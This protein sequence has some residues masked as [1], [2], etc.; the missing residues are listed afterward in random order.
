MLR[1]VLFTV[2]VPALVAHAMHPASADDL[3]GEYAIVV[4]KATNQHDEWSQVVGALRDKSRRRTVNPL[5]D[6]AAVQL[7]RVEAELPPVRP[8]GAPVEKEGL[9][10]ENI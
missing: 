8:R 4:S 9:A 7:Q 10:L 6:T 3:R 2:V 5:E 1:N